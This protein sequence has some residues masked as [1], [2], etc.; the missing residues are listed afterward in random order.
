M[1]DSRHANRRAPEIATREPFVAIAGCA[2][3]RVLGRF[4]A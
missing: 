3:G 4:G 2:S 1:T